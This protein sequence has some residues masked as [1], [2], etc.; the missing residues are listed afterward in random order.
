M[1]ESRPTRRP[2]RARARRWTRRGASQAMS[3]G[4]RAFYAADPR[5][6]PSSERDFGL[7]WRSAQGTTYRAAWIA[8]TQEL[9]SVRHGGDAE[10]A[11]VTVLA[12]LGGEALDRAFA[13]W[14]RI[15]DSDQPGSYEWLLERAAGVWR[16]AEPA[17]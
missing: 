14:R 13:G 4:L 11:E 3:A 5:R 12:R 1:S 10:H 6:A 8:D 7:R 17:F 16:A 9:Y 2:A 15:C